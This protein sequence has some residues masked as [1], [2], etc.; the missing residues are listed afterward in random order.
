MTNLIIESP[1]RQTQIYPKIA[2]HII[3]RDPVPLVE[4]ICPQCGR[5]HRHGIGVTPLRLS[6]CI[7]H[8]PV[9]Y[10]IVLDSEG[11]RG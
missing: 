4:I 8:D 11:G 6:H 1:N 7:D 2:G 9:L 10:E 5:T 3:Q